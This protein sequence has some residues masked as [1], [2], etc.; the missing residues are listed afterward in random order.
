MLKSSSRFL[1]AAFICGVPITTAFAQNVVLNGL[2]DCQKATNGRSYC[3]KQGAPAEAQWVPV[4]EE[5]FSQYQA[6]R[7]GGPVSSQTQTTVTQQSEST[8]VNNNV[9]VINLTADAA[10]LKGQI[11][12]LEKLLSEQQAVQGA[13]VDGSAVQQTIKSIQDRTLSI[14]SDLPRQNNRI[15]TIPD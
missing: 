14:E 10:T 6:A 11:A 15:I 8:V 3:K 1:I 4:S 13:N 2:Y 7:N 9:L 5:F 12:L